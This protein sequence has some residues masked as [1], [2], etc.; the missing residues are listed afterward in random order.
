MLLELLWDYNPLVD[1]RIVDSHIKNLRH[2][3]G[4]GVIETVR[5]LGYRVAQ[6]DN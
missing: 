4:E 2:K 6:K 1:D 5:G 3:L